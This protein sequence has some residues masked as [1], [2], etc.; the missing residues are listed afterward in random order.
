M[1]NPIRTTREE[2]SRRKAYKPPSA[3]DMPKPHSDDVEYRWIR[4]AIQ[5]SDDS[6]NL[7]SRRRE[8]WVPVR[9]EEHPD[10]DGPAVEEGK[11][12]GAIGIGD[13][14]L[15][16]NSFE[17]NEARRE[18]YSGRTA[19]QQDAIDNDLMREQ[20]PSMPIIKERSTKVTGSRKKSF[21]D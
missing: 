5:N 13:L 20:H 11:Y 17:N 15:M 14:V 12:A 21:D 8:G 6:K 9:A 10:F 4:V 19:T 18:Y 2:T 3:L 7:S 1:A 16:K